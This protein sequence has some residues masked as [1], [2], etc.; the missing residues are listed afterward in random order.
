MTQR[1]WAETPRFHLRVETE[2]DTLRLAWGDRSR[3][4]VLPSVGY[5]SWSLTELERSGRVLF[6]RVFGGLL[7][8]DEELNLTRPD[9]DWRL[10]RPE[11]IYLPE[12]GEALVTTGSALPYRHGL[13]WLRDRRI[14]GPGVCGDTTPPAVQGWRA[15]EPAGSEAID[16][17]HMNWD[18]APIWAGR[19]FIVAGANGAFEIPLD[20]PVRRLDG[21]PDAW[22]QVA[23][24]PGSELILISSCDRFFLHDGEK[25]TYASGDLT[26]F[27]DESCMQNLEPVARDSATGAIR[28]ARG[29]TLR[30]DGRIDRSGDAFTTSIA[31]RE[32][33]EMAPN[34]AQWPGREIWPNGRPVDPARKPAWWKLPRFGFAIRQ[35]ETGRFVRMGAD[36]V[37][38]RAPDQPENPHITFDRINLVY[39]PGAGDIL[40]VDVSERLMR[41]AA[42][43]QVRTVDCPAPCT[44]GWITTMDADPASASGA[45][46]GAEAGLFRYAPGAP[47]ERLL[48]V[49]QTGPVFRVQTV[50]LIGETLIEAGFGRFVWSDERGLR[51][52]GSGGG[53]YHPLR[54][55]VLPGE[56]MLFTATRIPARFELVGESGGEESR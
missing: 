48:P 46:I 53:A 1:R 40:A 38:V 26:W 44:L 29:W 49:A 37:P 20:G 47:L 28:L 12:T 3:E 30:V 17:A 32:G 23:W 16:T 56:R 27:F 24:V 14:S 19:A 4:V 39:D 35:D 21:L 2:G 5:G 11:A 7:L 33:L 34:P 8:I 52:L 10:S 22:T 43:G 51:R 41:I 6:R 18:V 36:L 25:I 54:L 42:D 31:W 15:T 55:F 50:P 45:L 9:G 13:S